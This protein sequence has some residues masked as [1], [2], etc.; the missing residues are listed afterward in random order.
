MPPSLKIFLLALAIIDDLGAIIIIALFYTD[1]L[2]LAAL[3][4]AVGGARCCW[5][6][7]TLAA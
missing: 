5:R 2:S 4:L 3:A 7:S 6:S 1:D